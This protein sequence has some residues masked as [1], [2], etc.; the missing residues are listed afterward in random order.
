MKFPTLPVLA[1][2]CLLTLPAVSQAGDD[3][4]KKGGTERITCT[5]DTKK[6][7]RLAQGKDLVI[8]PGEV[9]RDVVVIDGVVTV[10]AGAIVE[11]VVAVRGKVIVEAGAQVKENVVAV[12]GDARIDKGATVQGDAVVLGGRLQNEGGKKTVAGEQVEFSLNI[13]GEN[14]VQSFL[15][16]ALKDDARCH[17]REAEER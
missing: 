16:S 11:D 15:D 3:A 1:S 14:L 17:I 6:G 9:A 7:D 12:G 5:V 13:G 4:G 10:R 8:G 2:L